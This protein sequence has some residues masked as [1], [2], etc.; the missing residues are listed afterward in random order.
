[1][2]CAKTNT[3]FPISFCPAQGLYLSHQEPRLILLVDRVRL[4]FYECLMATIAFGL[5]L[6]Q[7]GLILD[8]VRTRR[9]FNLN[10]LVVLQTGAHA[11]NNQPALSQNPARPRKEAMHQLRKIPHFFQ[12][13]QYLTFV[14]LQTFESQDQRVL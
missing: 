12:A 4:I 14:V 5:L 6:S 13:I 10:E 11:L 9:V 1:M 3:A 8:P 2:G 7:Y